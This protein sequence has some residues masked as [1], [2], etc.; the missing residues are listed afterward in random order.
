MRR[1]AAPGHDESKGDIAMD[2][3]ARNL[4]CGVCGGLAIV[5][6]AGYVTEAYHECHPGLNPCDPPPSHAHV[7]STS[8]STGMMPS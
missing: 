1:P 2:S 5:L 8:T 4:A 6:A 3:R 7:L